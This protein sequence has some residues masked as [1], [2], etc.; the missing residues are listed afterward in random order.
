MLFCVLWFP[1]PRSP[2]FVGVV[3]EVEAQAVK[4]E[5]TGISQFAEALLLHSIHRPGQPGRI[6][7]DSKQ[8]LN[9]RAQPSKP[10]LWKH[11]GDRH[12]GG[13]LEVY[14]KIRQNC[15]YQIHLVELHKNI[16]P[17]FPLFLANCAYII[18]IVPIVHCRGWSLSNASVFWLSFVPRPPTKWL[19]IENLF[20]LLPGLA[21]RAWCTQ[22]L[23]SI[24][25]E[26][27]H[28][29]RWMSHSVFDTELSWNTSGFAFSSSFVFSFFFF[30]A[31]GYKYFALR[32]AWSS[33]LEMKEPYS[34]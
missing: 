7:P 15:S 14:T 18:Y 29:K 25:D 10:C 16:Q 28:W 27:F 1:F 17:G 30:F 12:W 34:K 9:I 31:C 33:F 8:I 20:T 21:K 26:H 5:L 6:H 3:E 11:V 13:S 32:E 24:W 23:W 22:G 19:L 2:A 4:W